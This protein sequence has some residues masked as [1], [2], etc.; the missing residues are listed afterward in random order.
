MLAKPRGAHGNH[1]MRRNEPFLDKTRQVELQMRKDKSREILTN[2]IGSFCV[3]F[4]WGS[5]LLFV[6][7]RTEIAQRR[8][9]N[10]RVPE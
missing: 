10:F 1:P 9:Y 6:V 7:D 2:W 3:Y 8:M 4:S 5:L